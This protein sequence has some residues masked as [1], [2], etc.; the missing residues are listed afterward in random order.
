MCSLILV[1]S[2]QNKKYDLIRFVGV[3]VFSNTFNFPFFCDFFKLSLK[4]P[5]T[6]WKETSWGYQ[7]IDQVL[8]SDVL[9]QEVS[10]SQPTRAAWWVPLYAISKPVVALIGFYVRPV[11]SLLDNQDTR[12]NLDINVGS[13]QQATQGWINTYPLSSGMSTISKKSGIFLIAPSSLQ[14]SWQHILYADIA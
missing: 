10:Y 1:D 2:G 14:P 5:Y 8:D 7:H 3:L 12:S 13:R 9:R 4:V 6:R 11:L